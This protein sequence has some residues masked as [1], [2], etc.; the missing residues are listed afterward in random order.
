MSKICKL[1]GGRAENWQSIATINLASTTLETM[2]RTTYYCDDCYKLHEPAI[3]DQETAY[4]ERRRAAAFDMVRRAVG[5]RELTDTE[6]Q[7]A[8]ERLGLRD[9]VSRLWLAEKRPG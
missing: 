6:L 5:D 3:Q 8:V 4:Y 1:C 2:S 7:A 9:E